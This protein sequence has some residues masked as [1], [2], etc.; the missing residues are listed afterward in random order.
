M[1]YL[2]PR[3]GGGDEGTSHEDPSTRMG[4]MHEHLR[5]E[6]LTRDPAPQSMHIIA[7]PGSAYVQ[8]TEQAEP[9]L[10][11][12][13]DYAWR[14]D[15]GARRVPIAPDQE[16]T[17]PGGIHA[18]GD[19]AGA[20]EQWYAGREAVGNTAPPSPRATDSGR[21]E[22]AGREQRLGTQNIGNTGTGLPQ[23]ASAEQSRFFS[24][25]EELHAR[26]QADE[27]RLA[28]T[29]RELQ[30]ARRGLVPA[31][32]IPLRSSSPPYPA[33]RRRASPP[34]VRVGGRASPPLQYRA[35]PERLYRAE[36]ERLYRAE[37]ERLYR[38]EPEQQPPRYPASADT[39]YRDPEPRGRSPPP[40][41]PHA[42]SSRAYG[43]HADGPGFGFGSPAFQPPLP[44]R[45]AYTVETPSRDVSPGP[46][47]SRGMAH[48]SKD[49]RPPSF[50][51]ATGLALNTTY[52][53]ALHA[54]FV[55][56]CR[57]LERDLSYE[58]QLILSTFS[59][60]SA[61]SFFLEM[62]PHLQYLCPN[63]AD[64]IG[65]SSLGGNFMDKISGYNR[66]D[67]S[68]S[69]EQLALPARAHNLCRLDTAVAR[70]ANR[71]DAGLHTRDYGSLSPRELF[72][73]FQTEHFV[74]AWEIVV[75]KFR[76]KPANGELK[77][78]IDGM[79]MGK[80]NPLD[81]DVKSTE[82]PFDWAQ[83]VIN[84]F[85]MLS[86]AA[87]ELFLEV[88]SGRSVLTVWLDGLPQAYQSQVRER[89]IGVHTDLGAI[90]RVGA[91]VLFADNIHALATMQKTHAERTTRTRASDRDTQRSGQGGSA[92]SRHAGA[93]S[94]EPAAWSA[95][96]AKEEHK[97]QDAAGKIKADLQARHGLDPA[98]AQRGLD[99]QDLTPFRTL[100][101]P[102]VAQAR[103][104]MAA[105]IADGIK[106]RHA[107]G[108]AESGR[109]RS[110]YGGAQGGRGTG[111]GGPGG[112]GPGSS[113][114]GRGGGDY[115][116]G[117]G[118]G[119]YQGGRSGG[120]GGRH[121]TWGDQ[122]PGAGGLATTIPSA[123]ASG[124][125]RP[126]A[127]CSLC[128]APQHSGGVRNC[129]SVQ[130][131]HTQRNIAAAREA[132]SRHAALSTSVDFSAGGAPAGGSSH[133]MGTMHEYSDD[134]GSGTYVAA[135]TSAAPH[136]PVDSG[137]TASS[138]GGD[139]A[140]ISQTEAALT[141][142]AQ[143]WAIGQA[144]VAVLAYSQEDTPMHATFNRAVASAS[145]WQEKRRYPTTCGPDRA[146]SG[147][148]QA[149]TPKRHQTPEHDPKRTRVQTYKVQLDSP[150]SPE[151]YFALLRVH[152]QLRYLEQPAGAPE[153]C[154]ILFVNE[155]A[156]TSHHVMV[157][158][159]ANCN[160]IDE[161]ERIACGVRRYPTDIRLTTSNG[162]GTEVLGI[163]DPI[164]VVYGAGTEEQIAV[165]HY[166]LVTQG[167]SHIYSVLLGN[168]DIQRFGGVID[169]GRN[170]LTLH[171][172]YPSLGARA[173]ALVLPT[174]LRSTGIR[175]QHPRE[176]REARVEG[177]AAGRQ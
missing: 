131:P 145:T 37:P 54:W 127:I 146:F 142:K 1:P 63:M 164:K 159:G 6:S 165:W 160:L 51:A 24:R 31:P 92:N 116:G 53:K 130:D 122:H 43:G 104:A 11:Q 102:A 90:E 136:Y 141:R 81:P 173:P 157:D 83:R 20:Y 124:S 38:T 91:V 62:V 94:A 15:R 138:R 139:A 163:T 52:L 88:A 47:G 50:T 74:I 73:G 59:G 7:Y 176:P 30:N 93:T 69:R 26:L 110:S 89:L 140:R 86:V 119:D 33:V 8:G 36:P 76:A 147:L 167:M 2:T 171:G 78:G 23:G 158:D 120:R 58:P 60:P 71:A 162:S 35:E 65:K 12:R 56:N 16:T 107:Q 155:K 150:P 168:L 13:G 4:P 96:L 72:A 28:A 5:P 75:H 22:E 118:G 101:G 151:E 27:Q 128:G 80:T 70:Y 25:A 174:V 66:G 42:P 108:S 175:V 48:F 113:L 133:S 64:T 148:P 177:A 156:H 67:T 170:T 111:Y 123:G 126:N 44:R 34:L 85:D 115:H 99:S 41:D 166:F 112:R 95:A 29:F 79:A 77:A 39:R 84:T 125:G 117:R 10:H 40:L 169:A 134:F 18:A 109:G 87:P 153:K 17:A 103:V 14:N 121:T 143:I 105:T 82:T 97:I 98:A 49:N 137:N 144:L 19:A 9:P 57:V 55:H 100:S 45:P 114:G 68:S 61:H 172:A 154:M 129:P 161:E 152:N 106:P 3:D 149:V 132:A 32:A 135:L 46:S 21:A